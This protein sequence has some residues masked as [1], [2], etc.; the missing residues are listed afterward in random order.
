LKINQTEIRKP[1][2]KFLEIT[3]KRGGGGNNTL[4][5]LG[6]PQSGGE[7]GGLLHFQVGKE[8]QQ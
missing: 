6:V 3:G 2:L 8:S 1:R 4:K 7:I 5:L